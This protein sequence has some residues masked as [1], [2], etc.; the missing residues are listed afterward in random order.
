MLT[1]DEMAIELNSLTRAT[2]TTT[3]FVTHS[4]QEAVLL[5]D[6]IFVMS[7]RPGRIVS[8]FAVGEPHPREGRVEDS[9]NMMQIVKAIKELIYAK[10]H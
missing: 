4:I 9:D 3:L 6:R 5:S 2:S 7:P 8:V 10:G 1:R